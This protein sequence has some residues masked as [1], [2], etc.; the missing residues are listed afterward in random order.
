MSYCPQAVVDAHHH[1]WEYTRFPY[2]WLHSD[3]PRPFGDHRALQRDY[4]PPDY[5]AAVGGVPV[6]ASVHVQAE[7][8]AADPVAET[9]WV[10]DLAQDTG[11]PDAAVFH[12]DL[13][14]DSAPRILADNA[15]F[16]LVRG[17]RA[18]VSW[19]PSGRF[20]FAKRPGVMGEATF[21]R[22]AA[23]LPDLGLSLDI[24][25]VPDQLREVADL[26]RRLPDLSIIVDHLG[27][28]QPATAEVW[29]T[30]IEAI[31]PHEN[32]ALK[33][34]GL[35][36]VDKGW[37]AD[38]LAPFLWHA[39][40]HLGPARLMYGSNAPIEPLNCPIPQQIATLCT[41]LAD[42]S[43]AEKDMIFANT[44]IRLYRLGADQ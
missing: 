23:M 18:P 40:K 14:A 21:L 7:C 9:A 39:C 8:G 24:V 6:L 33:V 16:A 37:R 12:V 32:V 5:R 15:A 4:L 27:T 30:G 35:W 3:A 22:H 36:T 19:H 34:S 17:V 1:L 26:A 31:A 41:I 42:L 38:I 2:I 20:S 10:A 28:A 13:T 43:K 44:A 29:Q 25:V 11:I